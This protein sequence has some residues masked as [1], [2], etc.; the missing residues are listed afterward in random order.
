MGSNFPAFIPN[1]LTL[2]GCLSSFSSLSRVNSSH[3]SQLLVFDLVFLPRISISSRAICLI[4]SFFV[5]NYNVHV[6]QSPSSPSYH[7]SFLL[8][9]SCSLS[10]SSHPLSSWGP[11]SS[12]GRGQFQ[13]L[14]S[15]FNP[16]FSLHFT[17]QPSSLISCQYPTLLVSSSPLSLT[18]NVSSFFFFFCIL[19]EKVDTQTATLSSPNLHRPAA[20]LVRLP[21]NLSRENSF[22]G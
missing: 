15:L 9:S 21:I 20:L 3:R 10:F 13:P 7:P 16:L 8:S 4:P 14:T 5:T 12:R 1:Y 19:I 17:S 6:T 11:K 22:G 18:L 2:A